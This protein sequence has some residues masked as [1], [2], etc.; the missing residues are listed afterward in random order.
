MKYNTEL[1]PLIIP[2]YGRHIHSM[3][4]SLLDIKDDK[5]RNQQAKVL[6]NIMGNLNTH[7]RDNEEYKHKLWDHLFI[8]CENKLNIDSPYAKPNLDTPVM[9]KER[10]HNTQGSVKYKH[11]GKLIIELIKEVIDIKDEKLQTYIVDHIAQQMKRSHLNWNQTN[12]QDI[13]IWN[14][15]DAFADQKINIDK[16]KIIPVFQP[17]IRKKVFYKKNNRKHYSRK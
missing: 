13:Q 9:I 10:I 2:E 12:V 7:L 14:D 17:N 6:I 4:N 8:M 3:V 15:L 1:T 11:Y 16:T 5:K